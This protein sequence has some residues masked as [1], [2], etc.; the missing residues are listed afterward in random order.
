VPRPRTYEREAAI[1]LAMD[2]FWATG[3]TAT[4]MRDLIATTGV[5]PASLYAE[6][7]GKDGLFLEAVDRYIAISRAWYETSLAAGDEGFAAVRRHL[8]SYDF[9]GDTRGCLLV[10]SLGERG[11]IPAPALARIDTFF[12]WVRQ[13]YARHLRAAARHGELRPGADPDALAS[14]LLAFDQG[15]AVAGKLPGERKRLAAS[16]RALL[17]VMAA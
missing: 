10:N 6:F 2:A 11:E 17:E 14:A 3:Y 1:E 13:R 7:G 8:E 16:V 15:L 5:P 12:R 4:S 9:G